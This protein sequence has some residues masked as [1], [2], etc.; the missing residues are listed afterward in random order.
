VTDKSTM[1]ESPEAPRP[2]LHERKEFLPVAIFVVL[3]ALV[4][5][6]SS[7]SGRPPQIASVS[8]T[9]GL[10]REIMVIRGRFFQR[11]RE[12]G[13]V[14]IGGVSPHSSDY[15]EWSDSTIKLR[16][17]D[18]CTSGIVSVYTADGKSNGV[19]FTNRALI[20]RVVSGPARPGEPYIGSIEPEKAPPGALVTLA[21]MNFGP[22]L[23]DSR[24]YFTW[25]SAE[26]AAAHDAKALDN[27][28]AATEQDGDYESWTELEIRVRVPDGATSGNV[29]VRTARGASNAVYLELEAGVGSKRYVDQRTYHVEYGVDV[30]DV[31]L[32]PGAAAGNALYVWVPKVISLPEQ[33][34][35]ELV[36]REPA[37]P[38]FED[39]GGLTGYL[40]SNLAAADTASIRQQYI[41]HRYAI[42]TNLSPERVVLDYDRARKLFQRYTRPDS[43][44][45]SDDEK[46]KSAAK[47]V[48]GTNKNPYWK[49]RLA[50]NYVI[51]R[52]AYDKDFTG[53]AAAANEARKGDSYAFATLFTALCRVAE[54]PARPVAGYL[55]QRD[56]QRSA[57]Q[58]HYWAEFYLERLGW[59]P[60]DPLLGKGE[61]I[62]DA[63]GIQNAA[64]YYFGNLDNR[65]ITFTKGE[66]EVPQQ[67][68][69]G[70]TVAR[71]RSGSLQTTHEEA[72]GNLSSY[73]AK[74]LDIEP[75][76]V[77]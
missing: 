7:L 72:V 70:R 37:K 5:I 12:G 43:S 73:T 23:Q 65:H 27:L 66:V 52:L 45:P 67:T 76:G 16:I 25:G 69:R 38:L 40:F 6:F 63:P 21:G 77:Y 1:N 2:K 60:A 10:P 18:D 47:A 30:G 75:I 19:L 49:A 9:V 26:A 3:A 71:P 56:E 51:Q 35:I 61:R 34:A 22:E 48:V 41:F 32:Q 14:R 62:I 4:A 39:F 55:V 13:E 44:V 33:R 36:R 8:P 29:L 50:Y 74:W 68:P 54:V 58:R 46:L 17:P 28:V 42:A 24:V 64:D 53:T 31:A 15:V 59:V 20:P 11:E 57:V